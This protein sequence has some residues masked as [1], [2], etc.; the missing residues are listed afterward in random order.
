MASG[1]GY[2]GLNI[3]KQAE[4]GYH[5]GEL[6]VQGRAGVEQQAGRVVNIMRSA[7][8]AVAQL[9]LQE[10]R[11]LVISSLDNRRRSWASLLTGPQGFVHA[12]DEHTL[13]IDARPAEGD[14]LSENLITG[15]DI[16][17]LAIE[18]YTRRRV[19]IKG[20]LEM[21]AQNLFRVHTSRV[22]ALCPKYIQAR[23][24]E[25]AEVI[26][27]KAVVVRS[28]HL[29]PVQQKWIGSSDTF[30]I[31]T[32]NSETGADASHRGGFPGFIHVLDSSR[33]VF[34]DYAGN[35]M[36]NTLGNITAHPGAGLF[37]LDFENAH[38]LQLSGKAEIVWESEDMKKFPGAERLVH[39]EAHEIIQINKAAP[40]AWRFH[41]YS[42][43]NPK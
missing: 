23:S 10:Q 32:Y 34:P 29:S 17:V 7:I 9:F 20:K 43:F 22:Y 37:F 40:F 8:P 30:F 26:R 2:F 16:G 27:E 3:S 39:F 6:E 36:F 11:M 25:T 4:L 33:L 24:M 19:K 1:T 5:A 28:N 31:A 21:I 15:R 41:G 13:E 38:S 14:P 35:K 12:I 42:P 18:F